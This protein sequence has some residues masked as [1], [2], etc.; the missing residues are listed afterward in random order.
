MD[1]LFLYGRVLCDA[2]ILKH[3]FDW[4]LIEIIRRF[5]LYL[6]Y[7]PHR[8]V[9]HDRPQI[10]KTMIDRIIKR[11]ALDCKAELVELGDLG[12]DSAMRADGLFEHKGVAM[13]PGDRGMA[14][15]AKRIF[16]V[17]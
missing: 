4:E 7:I 12:E 11:A 10:R 5:A 15:I 13:H 17:I 2:T 9:H 8:Q 14:A 3:K 6:A 16:S 1:D